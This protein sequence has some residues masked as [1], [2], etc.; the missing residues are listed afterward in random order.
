MYADLLYTY[1]ADMV[2]EWQWGTLQWSP[3]LVAL[4]AEALIVDWRET[5]D[6]RLVPSLGKLAD[7][8]WAIAWD[9]RSRSMLYQ[10]NPAN[11]TE[12]PPNQTDCRSEI[13]SPDLNL[14]IAPVYAWLF[15]QTGT[16]T[17]RDMADA[18]FDGGVRGGSIVGGPPK[19]FTQSYRWSFDYLTWRRL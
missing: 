1:A 12:C 18:L 4:M 2:D 13:G 16:T 11:T 19:Q 8:T 5:K 15:A 14:L 7:V 9:P 3:F 17:Y 10:A 6:A